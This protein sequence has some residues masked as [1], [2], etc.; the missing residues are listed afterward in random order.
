MLNCTSLMP[1]GHYT[2]GAVQIQCNR[3]PLLHQVNAPTFRKAHSG[4]GLVK[5]EV[6][7]PVSAVSAEPGR[8]KQSGDRDLKVC[9]APGDTHQ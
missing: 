4:A 1:A 9:S 5:A 6:I 3:Q 8:K 2:A 7:L